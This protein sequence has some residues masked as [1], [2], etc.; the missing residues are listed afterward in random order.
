VAL[1]WRNIY[2]H[3]FECLSGRTWTDVVVVF[4]GGAGAARVLHRAALSLWRLPCCPFTGVLW[5][6]LDATAL[7]C[8]L[9]A[10]ALSSI[11]A[12]CCCAGGALVLFSCGDTAAA[13]TRTPHGAL[14]HFCA[15][16]RGKAKNQAR[17][18]SSAPACLLVAGRHSDCC[19]AVT[20]PF[21]LSAYLM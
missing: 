11:R 8:C 4:L 15:R 2:L 1:A 3:L 13:R 10:S 17:K 6:H 12:A 18:L 7:C 19:F 21:W 16:A 5:L 14:L 20:W 9:L